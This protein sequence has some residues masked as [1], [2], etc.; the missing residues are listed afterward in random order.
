MFSRFFPSCPPPPDGGPASAQV[1]YD[2]SGG[3]ITFQGAD[4][5]SPIGEGDIAEGAMGGAKNYRIGAGSNRG[6]PIF[7]RGGDGSKHFW[8]SH[9]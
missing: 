2:F 6:A 9:P 3:A 8:D 4:S 7:A 5:G 1:Y